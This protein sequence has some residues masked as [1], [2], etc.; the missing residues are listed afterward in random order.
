MTRT[1]GLLHSNESTS[2]TSVDSSTSSLSSDFSIRKLCKL[3]EESFLAN[4]GY[5]KDQILSKTLQGELFTAKRFDNTTP[6]RCVA[7]KQ[8]SKRLYLRREAIDP[9][10]FHFIIDEDIVKE[11]FVLRHLTTS[12]QPIG[13]TIVQYIDFFESPDHYYLVMEHIQSNMNLKQ[14]VLTCHQHIQ[15]NK[16]K[17]SHYQQI[18]KYL[19][20]Q[21]AATLHW[22]HNDMKCYHLDLCPEN[23]MLNHVMFVPN[24]D[25]TL[26]I[27][28]KIGIKLVDFGASEHSMH[29]VSFKCNKQHISLDNEQ[30]LAPNIYKQSHYDAAAADMWSLGMLIYFGF[31]G[32]YPYKTIQETDFNEPIAGTPYHSIYRN[33]LRAYLQSNDLLKWVH[34]KAL[35]LLNGL[36]NVDEIERLRSS[37]VLQ[38]EWFESYYKRYS[39]QIDRKSSVQKKQLL[40]QRSC[41]QI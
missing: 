10:G 37:D 35:S 40:R 20:W 26:S 31:I 7:I 32:D 9:C 18:I 11:A 25:E 38:H 16:L 30:Y 23:I 24:N 14:F 19:L 33:E 21:L 2:N 8:T 17:R 15:R 5:I 34:P 41:T 29:N 36:L 28:R 39:S 1:L 13:G 6:H 12:N 3:T 22:L 27:H 4:N